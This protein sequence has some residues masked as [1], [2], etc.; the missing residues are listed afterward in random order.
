MAFSAVFLSN[1]KTSD[2]ERKCSE[3]SGWDSAGLII[4]LVSLGLLLAGITAVGVFNLLGLHIWLRLIKHM[5]T[6]D[7]IISQRKANKYKTP[8]SHTQQGS[9]SVHMDNS[10]SGYQIPLVGK[11]SRRDVS[12]IVPETPMGLEPEGGDL[13]CLKI[14]SPI[15]DLSRIDGKKE[16]VEKEDSMVG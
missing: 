4:S 5:S 7:Y 13:E 8:V 12:R 3:Y 15:T 9:E 2:F 11:S 16:A 14:K 6:Y 1:I 10:E